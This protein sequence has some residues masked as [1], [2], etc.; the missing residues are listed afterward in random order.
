MNIKT[1]RDNIAMSKKLLI[2]EIEKVDPPIT[3]NTMKEIQVVGEKIIEENRIELQK[4]E[5][6]TRHFM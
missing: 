4:A 6:D 1:V 2:Y 3:I 5:K